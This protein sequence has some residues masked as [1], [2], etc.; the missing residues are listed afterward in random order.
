MRREL[1]RGVE[2]R[3]IPQVENPVCMPA[4]TMT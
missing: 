1:G 2:G 4:I 3:R